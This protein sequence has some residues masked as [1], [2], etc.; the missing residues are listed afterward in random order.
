MT[1][2][3]R[4]T[5]LASLPP[6]E[7]DGHKG[8]YGH[9]LIV[10]GSAGMIGAV[11]LACNGALR[12]GVGLATFAA[13]RIVQPFIATLCPCATSVP[14]ACD[15]DGQLGP[16]ALRQMLEQAHRCNVVAVGPGMA[17]G[18]PQQ[19][20]VQALL[21]YHLPLVIDADGL[22]NLS[23]I[24]NWPARRGCPLVLTPHPGELSRLIGKPTAEIQADRENIAAQAARQWASQGPQDKPLVLVLKGDGTI[25]TDGQRLYTNDTGNP[26]L[27]TGGTGDVLTGLIAGILAQGI[28]PLEAACMAVHAHGRAGDLA[29]LEKGQVSLIASDLA[30]FLPE[31]M[32]EFYAEPF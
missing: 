19:N 2:I 24:N 7:A 30:D 8:D 3:E 4:I 20:L 1:D 25:V 11:A 13:P 6:R 21:E 15:E 9:A 32:M 29:A 31:A 27:A 16:E 26:G 5:T 17:I 18:S 22:N 23:Q 10:G 14:L 12:G 28:A